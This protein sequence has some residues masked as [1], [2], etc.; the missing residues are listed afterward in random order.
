MTTSSKYQTID[1]QA[2]ETLQSAKSKRLQISSKIIVRIQLPEGTWAEELVFPPNTII[3]GQGK[4]TVVKRVSFQGGAMGTIGV[5]TLTLQGTLS[6]EAIRVVGAADLVFVRNCYITGG[7]KN[8]TIQGAQPS[9]QPEQRIKR[10]LIENNVLL[11][12]AGA[13]HPAGIY[14]SKVDW[15]EIRRNFV[16]RSGHDKA[17]IFCHGMYVQDDCRGGI[18]EENV[19]VDACSHGVQQRN[20]SGPTGRLHRNLVV[21]CPCGIFSSG[22]L[23]FNVTENVVIESDDI[24]ST[25]PRGFGIEVFPANGTIVS[26]IVGNLTGRTPR[27]IFTKTTST[28]PPAEVSIAI[29]RNLTDYPMNLT[30]AVDVTINASN[31]IETGHIIPTLADYAQSRGMTRSELIE[32]WRDGL[33]ITGGETSWWFVNIKPKTV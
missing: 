4:K 3:A 5:E 30:P 8:I 21:G 18:I 29:E 19:V 32:A 33:S 9:G 14:L 20:G 7:A 6:N 28:Y 17:D 24:N 15:H 23:G 31:N 26:N 13:G 25:T 12:A 10:V 22:P 11:D 2:G 16:H 27:S 1:I